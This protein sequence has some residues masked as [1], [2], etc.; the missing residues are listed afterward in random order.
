ML[1]LQRRH[2]KKCPDQKKGPLHLKCRGRCLFRICGMQ[3]GKRVRLSL[4]TRDY[5]K[6][7]KRYAELS[8]AEV[9]SRPRK[10]LSDAIEAFHARHEGNAPET[11][12]KYKQKLSFLAAYCE[13]TH[14][15][16]VDQNNF[17]T[18][19]AYAAWRKK[20]NWT[21]IKEIEI[22]KQFFDF[23]RDRE[24]IGMNPAKALKRPKLVEANDVVP[25]TSAE[26]ARIIRACDEFGRTKYER[27]R[28]RAMVLLMRY[29]GLRISDVITL[30]RD[31]IKGI[32]LE[33]Q[34]V[35]NHRWIR[36]ELHSDVLRA[37]ETIPRPKAA[38]MDCSLFFCGETASLRSLVKGAW[39]TLAAVFNCAMVPRAHPHRFRHTLASELLGKGATVEEVAGILAD[40]PATIRR[41]YAKWT[42]ELQARQD[43]VIRLVHGTNLAQAEEQISKC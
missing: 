3:N 17:E 33:K 34:S 8:E 20:D 9:I 24:W 37:L 4:K 1:I 2:S 6:A 19:D 29:A 10:K 42:P 31:H 38:S 41:H 22:L 26:I 14:L 39:R 12:R 40:S 32:R 35:K 7:Q 43:R 25:Y 27:L 13:R 36:V 30:S 18:M 21:W 5:Q 15:H 23:C 11:T 28:A 16:Y